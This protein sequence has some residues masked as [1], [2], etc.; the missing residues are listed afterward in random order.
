MKSTREHIL[1]FAVLC[2]ISMVGRADTSLS[3]EWLICEVDGHVVPGKHWG[4][5]DSTPYIG[6]DTTTG[7]VWGCSGCNRL[8]GSVSVDTLERT[9]DMGTG[10]GTTR[11]LCANMVLEDA[12]LGALTRVRNYAPLTDGRIALLDEQGN[13]VVVLS[14]LPATP[15]NP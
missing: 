7:R 13:R 10:M 1:L 5:L 3:G 14:P 12:L 9:L 2:C 11:M 15:S 8:L 4:P 6:F